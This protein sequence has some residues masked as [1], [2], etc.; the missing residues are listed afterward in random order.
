MSGAKT[1]AAERSYGRR[2][3]CLQLMLITICAVLAIY[4]ERIDIA[5]S[6]VWGGV[7]ALSNVLLLV[8]RMHQRK[9]LQSAGKQ[10]GMMYRSVVERFFVVICLLVIGMLKMQ[11]SPLHVMLGF[12]VAQSALILVS[13][14]SVFG[15]GKARNNA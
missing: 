6:L 1:F 2:V 4:G 10:L 9:N 5:K 8:W 14:M 7:C 12:V 15:Q 11:L 3:I 13:L